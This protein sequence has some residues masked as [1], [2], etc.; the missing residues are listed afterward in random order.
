MGDK[1]LP[2]DNDNLAHDTHPLHRGR[3]LRE[4]LLSKGL[5][6]ICVGYRSLALRG[7]A[8]RDAEVI[9]VSRG[10]SL[11]IRAVDRHRHFGFLDD[12]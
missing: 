2:S 11:G 7:M 10:D 6:H 3:H 9:R 4:D 8:H 1:D 5:N 12:F